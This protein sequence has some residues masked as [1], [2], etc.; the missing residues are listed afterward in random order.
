MEDQ[1]MLGAT[2]SLAHL[3][4]AESLRPQ[5]LATMSSDSRS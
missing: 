4:L 2:L 3:P 5:S 1:L